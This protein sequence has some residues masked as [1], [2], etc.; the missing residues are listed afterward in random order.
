MRNV[1]HLGDFSMF[2]YTKFGAIHVISLQFRFRNNAEKENV[3]SLQ[4]R[5]QNN[6]EKNYVISLQLRARNKAEKK[7][8]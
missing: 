3:I 1:L 5:S 6:A 7:Y 2:R 4:F 8:V